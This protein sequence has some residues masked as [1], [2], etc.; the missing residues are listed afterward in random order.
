MG[1]RHPLLIPPQHFRLESVYRHFFCYKLSTM[2]NAHLEL[3][4]R[5]YVISQGQRV[6]LKNLLL[7]DKFHHSAFPYI[8]EA[9]G[10]T[11][12]IAVNTRK[13]VSHR[14][15]CKRRY[16]LYKW[17]HSSSH[18]SSC[19]SHCSR[20]SSSNSSSK[21]YCCCN[22]FQAIGQ[23]TAKAQQLNMF[24]WNCGTVKKYW[25]ADLKRCRLSTASIE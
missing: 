8:V 14:L 6:K 21:S 19:S 12:G 24:C 16:W 3:C 15:P 9:D 18:S 10:D 20:S 17:P 1:K 13:L 23:A 22:E 5:T 25:L 11:R 7:T 2:S 4:K